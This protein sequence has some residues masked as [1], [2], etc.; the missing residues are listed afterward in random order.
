MKVG[1]CHLN[2]EALIQ[3]AEAL[4]DDKVREKEALIQQAP[5]SSKRAWKFVVII[6]GAGE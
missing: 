3:R 5:A 6:T 1:K 4:D 2:D